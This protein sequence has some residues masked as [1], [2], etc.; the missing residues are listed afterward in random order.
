MLANVT[1][2][3]VHNFI[4]LTCRHTLTAKSQQR[5]NEEETKV[6]D[7]EHVEV[8]M[9]AAVTGLRSEFTNTITARITPGITCCIFRSCSYYHILYALMRILV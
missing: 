2:H 7:L 9:Q 8:A 1:F 5:L 6:I 4:A 3:P